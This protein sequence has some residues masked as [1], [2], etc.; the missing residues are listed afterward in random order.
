M[1]G[2]TVAAFSG[3]KTGEKSVNYLNIKD[4]LIFMRLLQDVFAG[5]H[6]PDLAIVL[7]TPGKHV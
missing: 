4:N 1:H 2:I 3:K 5:G 6:L 7:L